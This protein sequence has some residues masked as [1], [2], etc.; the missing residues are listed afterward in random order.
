MSDTRELN[1][2]NNNRHVNVNEERLVRH[3][4]TQILQANK[5]C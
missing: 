1:K 4:P 3:N 2:D 5:E